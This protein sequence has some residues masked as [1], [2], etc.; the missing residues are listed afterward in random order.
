MEAAR[1]LEGD[2]SSVAI[3]TDI[4]GT[5]APIVPTP[6]MSEVPEELR[7]LLRE[8]S[9]RYLWSPASAEERRRTRST[10]SG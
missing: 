4:D 5:L 6:D 10:S 2:P 8:L 1:G 9:A 3:L 7:G